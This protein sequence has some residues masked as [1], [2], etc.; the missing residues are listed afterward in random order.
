MEN[1]CSTPRCL[2]TAWLR[3]P[4]LTGP[5]ERPLL[6]CQPCVERWASRV[7]RMS[8]ALGGL[9]VEARVNWRAV[10]RLRDEL[11]KLLEDHAETDAASP[12][13]SVVKLMDQLLQIRRRHKLARRPVS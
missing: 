10:I 2:G 11:V 3:V 1:E 7:H 12:L 8:S 13:W 5:N 4:F 9:G 6:L